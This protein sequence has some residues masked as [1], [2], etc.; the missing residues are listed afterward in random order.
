M[1]VSIVHIVKSVTAF[2]ILI[3]LFTACSHLEPKGR[4]GA[5]VEQRSTEAEIRQHIVGAW[6]VSDK[7]NGC[8]YPTLVIAANG[9]LIGVL[10]NGAK[11]DLGTWEMSNK[12][13]RVTP[14]PASIEAA[15]ASG[16]HLNDWDYFPI[17]YADDHELVM[18]PGISMAG[19]WRY[20]K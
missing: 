4:G 20:K 6:T 16:F 1:N 10:T 19:R 9:R 7:S 13:L 12:L 2:C 11:A 17:V 5:E 3:L 15:R 8:W 14:T 18:T